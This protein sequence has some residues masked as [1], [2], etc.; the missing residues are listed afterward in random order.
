MPREIIQKPNFLN[1]FLALQSDIQRK[2]YRKI[3]DLSRD[4]LPN[5]TD[6]IK[7]QKTTRGNKKLYRYKFGNHRLFYQFGDDWVA[8][9]SIRKRNER[10]YEVENIQGTQAQHA[11]TS[12][13]NAQA[14]ID[15]WEMEQDQQLIFEPYVP[16]QQEDSSTEHTVELD[17]RPLPFA[18]TETLL[19]QLL[20]PHDYFE[21]ILSC[22]TED[23]VLNI[24]LPGHLHDRLLNNIYPQDI[25]D[26]DNEPNLV[27][28]NAEDLLKFKDGELIHFLL[29][30][31]EEQEKIVDFAIKGPTLVKGGAGTGKS[32]IA[33]Y[34]IQHILKQ[35]P[36]AKILFATYTNALTKV[37]KQMLRQL[38][39][40]QQIQQ[41]KVETVDTHIRSVIRSVRDLKG[42]TIASPDQVRSTI[43]KA[44]EKLGEG[45]RPLVRTL[46]QQAVKEFSTRYIREELFGIISGNNLS[47][48]EYLSFPRAGRKVVFSAS[49]R[50]T[51]WELYEN[52][53]AILEAQGLVA[54]SELAKEAH[55]LLTGGSA[56]PSYDYILID[57][58]QDLPVTYLSVLVESCR[59][60]EGL[61]LAA[62]MKQSIYSVNSWKRRNDKLELRGRT[63]VLKTNY[64]STKQI[65]MAAYD[66][67]SASTED[68]E[69]SNSLHSGPKP[70]V[71]I[72]S[73]SQPEVPHMLEFIRT[74]LQRLRMPRSA[75]A[76]LVPNSTVGEVYQ[77]EFSKHSDF[78]R[79]YS[80]K[81]VDLDAKMMKIM[82]LHTAKG[83]EFP[84]VVLA[85]FTKGSY[86]DREKYPNEQTYNERNDQFRRL[87]YVGM[88]R[89]MRDL[90]VIYTNACTSEPL[91]ELTEENWTIERRGD[92]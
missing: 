86:P 42:N 12:S 25:D 1:E 55:V 71:W 52:F 89:A 39:T 6:K 38:L 74:Q 48:E 49:L 34:R 37:S 28:Q 2:T 67:L 13:D 5:G 57:E 15:Q 54:H 79:F 27:L 81:N 29:Q 70:S 87:L 10:T 65:D 20:I 46:K 26:I 59:S 85:G 68:R 82:T 64:R 24:T 11:D 91:L 43:R 4:P 84:I 3:S 76:I 19:T 50:Q 53:H 88:T 16:V 9:L 31:D 83:L 58:A 30:L 69:T 77:E 51:F 73:D 36:N 44:I 75:V 7:L 66:V 33:L 47:K 56:S 90:L 23:D 80:S 63:R 60:P 18:L 92:K 14:L 78:A 72:V 32:T 22:Q 61:F 62:D 45:E 40:E 8:I 17:E 41:V 35:D 21:E